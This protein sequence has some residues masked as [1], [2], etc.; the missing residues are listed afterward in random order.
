ML[1]ILLYVS[2]ILLSSSA[3]WMAVIT[4]CVCVI[5]TS[6]RILM[7]MN[8][9]EQQVV[10]SICMAICT[11]IPGPLMPAGIDRE[12]LRI[13]LGVLCRFPAGVSCVAVSAGKREIQGL[14]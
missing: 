8:A 10:G 1:L 7:T 5:A 12:E 11:N 2:Y 9:I 13:V 6:V 3:S 4:L 14:M